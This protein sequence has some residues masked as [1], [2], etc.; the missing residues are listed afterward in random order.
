MDF[1]GQ[2]QR[3]NLCIL[4]R[5]RQRETDTQRKGNVKTRWRQR[6]EWGGRKPRTEGSQQEPEEGGTPFP[7]GASRGRAALL[8]P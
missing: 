4:I 3:A 1:F 2:A 8:I 5:E 7:P 6:P